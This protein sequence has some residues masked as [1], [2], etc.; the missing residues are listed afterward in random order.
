MLS[1]FHLSEA[2]SDAECDR[3]IEIADAAAYDDAALVRGGRRDNIR[4]ARVTWLDETREAGWIFDRITG[5][6]IAANRS[7]FGLDLSEFAERAQIAWYGAEAGG[8]F[9]WHV[10]IGDGPLAAKRKLTLVVQL[11]HDDGYEGGALELNARGHAEA[12]PRARGGAIMF[13]AFT[14]HRVSPV[15]SGA[16]YSLTTW[17]HGPAFR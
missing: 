2:F 1:P 8:H 15:T 11:S 4:K 14:P 16:R 5:T 10:D 3:I 7:H 13:P 9:D 12:A 17:V 6:V